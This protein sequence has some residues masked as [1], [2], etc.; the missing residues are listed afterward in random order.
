MRVEKYVV[1][2]GSEA[3]I[4]GGDWNRPAPQSPGG[5]DA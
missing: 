2:G 3:G 1:V 4:G 5:H